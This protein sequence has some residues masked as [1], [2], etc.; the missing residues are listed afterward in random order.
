MSKYKEFSHQT[1]ENIRKQQ[2]KHKKNIVQPRENFE[3]N[4]EFL[5]YNSPK[6]LNVSQHDVERMAKKDMRLA[7][8]LSK[9]R[10][11]QQKKLEL[12]K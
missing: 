7:K 6:N 9:E 10:Y 3:I 11:K 2:T 12:D 8:V 1:K 5:K 4:P